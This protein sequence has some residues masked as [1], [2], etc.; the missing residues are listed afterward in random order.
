MR[1]CAWRRRR[2]DGGVPAHHDDGHAQ[3]AGGGPLLEQRDAVGIGHPD[4]EQHEIG[5]CALARSARF[6]RVLC[7]FH[8]VALVIENF[9]EQVPDAQLVI[10]HENVCHECCLLCALVS[11]MVC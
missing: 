3:E 9:E 6:G 7:E 2:V 8:V 10:D 11:A 1:R 4:V 5:S